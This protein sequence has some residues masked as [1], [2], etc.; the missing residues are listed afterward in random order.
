MFAKA[1]TKIGALLVAFGL[2]F[3]IS[4]PAHAAVQRTVYFVS[5]LGNGLGV[6]SVSFDPNNSNVTPTPLTPD[7]WNGHVYRSLATDGTRLYFSD[8]NRD[9]SW[10]LVSTNLTGGDHQVITSGIDTPESIKVWSGQ[11]FYTTWLGGL[12]SVPITGGAPQSL[13]GPSHDAGLGGSVPTSGY[14]PFAFVGSHVFIDVNAVGI[15]K[16]NW[17]WLNPSGAEI[18][19][20]AGYGA[21]NVTDWYESGSYLSPTIYV[22]GWNVS[23]FKSTTD[24]ATDSSSWNQVSVSF[25]GMA[26]TTAYKA[27]GDSD[28]L[29][30]T[31]GSGD[32]T[33]KTTTGNNFGLVLGTKFN[34]E[35]YGIAVV[36]QGSS[37]T[38]VE[39][40][41]N[42]GGDLNLLYAG[43]TLIVMGIFAKR[44]RKN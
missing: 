43:L 44:L 19:S 17:L 12:F 9:G 31:S 8:N 18:V 5:T 27:T 13:I 40:L 30:F 20:P 7:T 37:D 32:I 25:P 21:F 26:S 23:G 1:T 29:F 38:P 2:I 28:Y 39:T 4:S 3:A 14:G 36:D 42:T 11:V 15:I 35:N 33:F 10:D 6:Y 24:L 22:S 34:S 16:A 41:A